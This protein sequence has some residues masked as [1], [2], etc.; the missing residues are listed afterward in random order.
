MKRGGVG[1]GGARG[2]RGGGHYKNTYIIRQHEIS[3]GINAHGAYLW[4]SLPN[5]VVRSLVLTADCELSKSDANKRCI[6]RGME[7]AGV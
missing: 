3:H 7:V 6:S 1:R 5:A 4:K 2:A